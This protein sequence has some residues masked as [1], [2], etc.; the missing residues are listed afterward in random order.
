MPTD[1]DLGSNDESAGSGEHPGLELLRRVVGDNLLRHLSPSPADVLSRLRAERVSGAETAA[2]DWAQAR[3]GS[4]VE[5][6]SDLPPAMGPSP[7]VRTFAFVDL[8]GFT[9]FTDTYGNRA[10]TDVLSVFRAVLR[11]VGARRGVRVAKWLGDGAMLVG[12]EPGPVVATVAEL[13]GR[14][15]DAELSVRGGIA[16]GESLLFESDDYIG[17]SVNLA[18]RLCDIAGPGVCLAG[19]TVTDACPSWVEVVSTGARNVRSVGRVEG[20]SALALPA[21]TDLPAVSYVSDSG[22][23]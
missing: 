17:R 4:G 23:S 12:V 1:S 13:M 19:P 7:I 6:P 8:C 14:F 18:A 15:G 22:D 3:V 21:D 9:S 20:V 2:A 10:A 16:M 11:E 5:T